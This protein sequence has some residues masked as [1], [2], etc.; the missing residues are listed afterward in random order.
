MLCD[1]FGAFHVWTHKAVCHN[2][3]RLDNQTWQAEWD[4]AP[5]AKVQL[6]RKAQLLEALRG[7]VL[8]PD[9]KV[10]WPPESLLDAAHDFETG[11]IL[12]YDNRCY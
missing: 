6:C 8:M 11:F 9:L 12:E 3:A 4:T 10:H 7:T 2:H 5:M 1:K